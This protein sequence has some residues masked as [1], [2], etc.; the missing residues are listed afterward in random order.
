MKSKK[1]KIVKIDAKLLSTIKGGSTIRNS[2]NSTKIL[3]TDPNKEVT[4]EED[5]NS[6]NVT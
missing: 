4:E 5:A 6:K 3:I 2:K 1:L